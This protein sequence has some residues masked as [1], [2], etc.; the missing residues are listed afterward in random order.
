MNVRIRRR[1]A[2]AYRCT[3]RNGANGSPAS[4][5]ASTKSAGEI[6]HSGVEDLQVIYGKLA[7]D[8]LI[9]TAADVRLRT[10]QRFPITLTLLKARDIPVDIKP[11]FCCRCRQCSARSQTAPR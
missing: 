3:A 10:H 2:N 7:S 11:A 4:G 1:A 6:G 5:I 9:V 8:V